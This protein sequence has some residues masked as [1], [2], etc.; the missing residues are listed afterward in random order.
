[1]LLSMLAE[2][3]PFLRPLRILRVLRVLRP[4]RLISRNAGMKLIINSL[5]KALPA[6]SNV[7]A[8]ILVLQLIFAILGMQVRAARTHAPSRPRFPSFLTSPVTILLFASH[9]ACGPSPRPRPSLLGL[10]S[11]PI[12]LFSASSSAPPRQL[13]ADTMASCNNP[14]ILFK[15]ECVE[16][17]GRALTSMAPSS[18]FHHPDLHHHPTNLQ[19]HPTDLHRHSRSLKGSGG[20]GGFAWDGTQKL[21]WSNPSA[22]SFDDF[23]SAMRLLYVMS[24]GDQWELHAFRM[25]GATG[26]G[27]APERLDF[28]WG[29]LFPLAWMFVGF[30]F[31]INLFVGV[32]VDQFTRMQTMQNG[33]ASMTAEQQQWVATMQASAGKSP[34]QAIKLPQHPIRRAVFRLIN[35]AG[36]DGFITFIIVANIGVMACDYWGIEN[37]EGHLHAYNSAMDLFSLVYYVECILKLIGLA[38][39]GYFGDGWNRFDFTLVCT[40]LVDQFATELLARYLPLPP[41]LLRVLRVFRILRILRLLKGAKDLRDLIVTMVLSLPALINVGSLLALV[42]FIYA[43][44]GVNAFTF[45]A[46]GPIGSGISDERNFDSFGAS[47]LVLFQCLT[48]DDWSG[49]MSDAM[50]DEQSSNGRCTADAA[51][52]GSPLAAPFFISF[53]ILGSFVLLN[54]V[55]AVILENFATLHNANPEL[56]SAPDIELFVAAWADFDPDATNYIPTDELPA[57]LLTLPRPLGLRGTSR[58]SRRHAIKLCMQLEVQQHNGRVTFAE[59]LA[60]LIDFNYFKTAKLDESGFKEIEGTPQVSDDAARSAP[61]PCAS[62]RSALTDR[63]TAACV[64]G[65][66]GPEAL[67]GSTGAGRAPRCDGRRGAAHEG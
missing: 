54:L 8:V 7:V 65:E 16:P 24:T 18:A 41:M 64:A 30:I 62:P 33:T 47:C 55:V 57:L 63:S 67:Q 52:C 36:F 20:D 17:T 10:T 59:V 39:D 50:I 46:H 19:H 37:N 44:I 21:F 12:T 9:L 48:G 22:G 3:L 49:V 38:P 26:P 14:A 28:S 2:H 27:R 6:V 45:I 31:A 40:S 23:G 42:M 25:M 60:V 51:D 5:F 4:L 53:Q 61:L 43:V 11:S 66:R 1:M 13:F 34:T 15:D 32:V 35:S 29:I 58:N 56:V